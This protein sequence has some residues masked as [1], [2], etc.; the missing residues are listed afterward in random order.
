MS[1]KYHLHQLIKSLSVSEKGYFKKYYGK[2]GGNQS[3]MLLFDAMDAMDE[4][5]EDQIK[6]QFK[7]KGFTKQFSVAKNYLIKNVLKSLRAYH[8]ES[9]KYIELNELMTDI[10]V[11]YQRRLG[12]LCKKL[13]KKARKIMQ[14]SELF[15]KYSELAFWEIKLAHLSTDSKNKEEW[16]YQAYHFAQEGLEK[17][18]NLTAYRQLAYQLFNMSLK[19]GATRQEENVKLAQEFLKNPLLSSVEHAQSITAKGTYYNIMSKIYEMQYDYP[20]CY[21]ASQAFVDLIHANPVIFEGHVNSYVLPAHYNLLL[22]CIYL[23]KQEPFFENL[24]RTEQIPKRYPAGDHPALR[25]TVKL[26]VAN[27]EMQ[28]YVQNG[29]FEEALAIV[30]KAEQVLDD[31]NSIG[32]LSIKVEIYYNIA[33]AYFGMGDYSESIDWLNKFIQKDHIELREDLL[34]YAWLLNLTNHYELK[35]YRYLSYKLKTTYNYISK[36]KK[37]HR[38]EE[39]TLDFIK[40]LIKSKDEE[41]FEATM[42]KFRDIFR[43]LAKDPYERV[44]LKSFDIL[45]WLESHLSERSFAEIARAKNQ[46]LKTP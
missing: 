32:F 18:S 7:N 31:D 38:F 43:E 25:K 4:Y 40:K 9:S 3:Y 16:L 21:Q 41:Q 34:A 28:Y 36:M 10:E 14:K 6:A 37:V 35:N 33:Y 46:S 20:K 5:D 30:P 12:D 2:Y 24:K 11:L 22:T 15:H 44:A 26:M 8:S 1:Q 13:V 27:A 19:E 39:T 42:T 29:Y 23:N 17:D 45:S